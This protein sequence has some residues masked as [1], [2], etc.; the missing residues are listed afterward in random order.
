MA[1]GVALIL[2]VFMSD[3]IAALPA[4]AEALSR[5]RPGEFRW[6]IYFVGLLLAGIGIG[7]PIV[8]AGRSR[9]AGRAR[10]AGAPRG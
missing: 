9:E 2:Y 5:V 6:G 10:E 3:A 1:S 7:R 4:T 8:S